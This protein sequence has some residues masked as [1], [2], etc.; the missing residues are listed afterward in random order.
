MKNDPK[1][2]V[3]SEYAYPLLSGTANEIGGA[4]LQMTMLAKELLKRSYDVSFVSFGKADYFSQIDGL[5]IY[6]PFDVKNSGFTYL[7]PWNLLSLFKTL[8]SIDAD[9][10][11]QR[12]VTPLTGFTALFCRLNNKKFIYSVASDSDVDSQLNIKNVSDLKKIIYKIGIDLSSELVCQSNL[13]KELLRKRGKKS[14]LIKNSYHAPLVTNSNKNKAKSLWVGRISEEKRPDLYLELAERVP[15]YEFIMIGAY[16][17]KNCEYY[18]SI[19]KKASKIENLNFLGFVP[20]HMINEY[21]SQSSLLVNTSPIE[22]FP[23]TFLESWG[24]SIPVVSFVDP[25]RVI[26]QKKLGYC[27]KDF[28]EMIKNVKK[29]LENHDLRNEMGKNGRMS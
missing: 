28:E 27:S 20:H 24:N 5:K 11:I 4:E 25:D 14:R 3:L 7:K 23:N 10:Y 29:L 2:C 6:N 12:G 21:Y 8:K 22:G 16:S 17:Q 18:D 19:K 13:Q 15:E 26:S 1:I 9:I